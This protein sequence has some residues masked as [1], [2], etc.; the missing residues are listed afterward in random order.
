MVR[1]RG[2]RVA[3]ARMTT[4]VCPGFLALLLLHHY[5]STATTAVLLDVAFSDEATY[6]VSVWG[7]KWLDSAPIR[8][9]T[10]G[11]WQNLTRQGSVHSHGSDSLGAFT[12]INVSWW[13][14]G[15]GG[16]G[17]SSSSSGRVGLGGSSVPAGRDEAWQ[18]RRIVLHT[19]LKTY[20]AIDTAIFV[21]QLPS[22]A[23]GTNASNPVLPQGVREMDPGNYPPVVAFPSL[24]GGQLE[25]LGF[26]TW[27]SR[28][29]NVEWGVN[30]T[31]GSKGANE[32]LISGRGL[33]GL[34]TNG[35]VVLYD[36]NF[37][38]LVVAP[39][40]NFKSAVHHVRDRTQSTWDLGISSE[41]AEL[42]PGF[43]HRTMLTAAK[44]ITAALDKWGKAFRQA[45][46][47][48]RTVFDRNIEYLSYW[49]DNVRYQS[50]CCAPNRGAVVPP[51]VGVLTL[52]AFGSR[53]LTTAVALGSMNPEAEA[54]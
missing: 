9:Y 38:S 44:G 49:T 26:V 53:V 34:A 37:T 20:P 30:V 52:R 12:C 51:R 14:S 48:N 23:S 6:S 35:P 16:G 27:Q 7:S 32:P 43:E 5:A 36:A 24:T 31:S 41:L 47:T 11:T 15:G 46:G 10:G 25:S 42:P 2:P 1:G 33:Q 28:M 40:D 21:Q 22:G 18:R 19:S 50:C 8:V 54:K 17:S 39:M 3:R 45:Y 29:I 4:R 13:V